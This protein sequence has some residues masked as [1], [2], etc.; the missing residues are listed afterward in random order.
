MAAR[1]KD[2]TWS[3]R[4]VVDAHI[5]VIERVN[6]TLNAM[7]AERFALARREA[8]EADGAGSRGRSAGRSGDRRARAR[9]FVHRRGQGARRGD[10]R[11]EPAFMDSFVIAD[12]ETERRSTA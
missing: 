10:R 8:D 2:R 1:I 5:A 7:V 12:H 4:E 11:V 3:S 6:P 9:S